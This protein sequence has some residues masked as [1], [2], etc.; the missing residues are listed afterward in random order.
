VSVSVV[1]KA[2]AS[3][4]ARQMGA[5]AQNNIPAA[6]QS[7]LSCSYIQ[8]ETFEVCLYAASAV[9]LR[10]DYGKFVHAFSYVQY[11]EKWLWLILVTDSLLS[12]D[13]ESFVFLFATQKFK[14]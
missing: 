13:A 3:S 5:E 14:D 6:A 9:R 12:F 10:V 8:T 4:A 1:H 11:R 2:F 7:T